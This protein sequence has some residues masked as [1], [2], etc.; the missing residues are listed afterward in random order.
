MGELHRGWCLSAVQKSSLKFRHFSKAPLVCLNAMSLQDWAESLRGR[1]AQQLFDFTGS[2]RRMELQ[3][4]T[5]L[6]A[7]HAE[8]RQLAVCWGYGGS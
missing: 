7:S 8:C 1:T 3:R 5:K 2:H 6:T 4:H